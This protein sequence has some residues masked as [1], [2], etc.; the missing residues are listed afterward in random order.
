MQSNAEEEP[1]S[2]Q[3]PHGYP[4]GILSPEHGSGSSDFVPV[5]DDDDDDDPQN[6]YKTPLLPTSAT[7]DG[8]SP[9]GTGLQDKRQRGSAPTRFLSFVLS[10]IASWIQGPAQPHQYKITPLLGRWQSAPERIIDHYLPS[11]KQKLA[12]L[13]AVIGIWGAL[14]ISVIHASVGNGSVSRLSCYS[15]LW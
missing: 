15:S 7:A 3:E 11:T 4:L 5:D 2:Y 8:S 14:F 1:L 6:V 10:R 13:L 12:L 9:S